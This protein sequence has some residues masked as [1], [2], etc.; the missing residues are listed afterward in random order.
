MA[1]THGKTSTYGKGCR[2]DLCREANRLKVCRTR[3]ALKERPFDEI[4]HGTWSGYT[5]YSCRCPDCRRANKV[6][7]ALQYQA[8]KNLPFDQ[9]PHGLSGYTSYGC[10]CE[11]CRG[12]QSA[13]R[14]ARREAKRAA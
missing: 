10:R 13:Y 7:A 12:S 9:I 1:R 5:N 4:P 6:R 11:T 3:A 14:R 2:C 8:R